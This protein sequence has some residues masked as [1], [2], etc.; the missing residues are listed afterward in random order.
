MSEKILCFGAK[1]GDHNQLCVQ[2]YVKC[3]H[4]QQGGHARPYIFLNIKTKIHIPLPKNRILRDSIE[5]NTKT[6]NEM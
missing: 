2:I 1:I 3:C 6:R 5:K 4:L